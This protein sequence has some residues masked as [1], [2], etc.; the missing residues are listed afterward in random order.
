MASDQARIAT[1]V[2]IAAVPIFV[3]CSEILQY[4]PNPLAGLGRGITLHAPLK[5]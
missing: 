5:I 2:W 1:E 3:H 4:S